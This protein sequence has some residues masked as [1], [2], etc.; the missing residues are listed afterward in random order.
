LST[1]D[2]APATEA[3]CRSI[4][5]NSTGWTE[6]S[7]RSFMVLVALRYGMPQESLRHARRT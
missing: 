7:F 3:T 4:A 1:A 6:L 5:E 2:S